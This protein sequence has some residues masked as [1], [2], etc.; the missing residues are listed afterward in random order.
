MGKVVAGYHATVFAYGQT[1][2]GK[3]YTMEGFNYQHYNGA[4]APSV[5]VAKPK[6]RFD[7][8]PEQHG[9]V[10]RAV[11]S[12][13]DRLAATTGA[14]AAWTALGLQLG[15]VCVCVVGQPGMECI[16]RVGEAG[17]EHRPRSSEGNTEEAGG[18]RERSEVDAR[19]RHTHT[20]VPS[21]PLVFLRKS[22]RVCPRA[23]RTQGVV[24]AD[25]A[26]GAVLSVVSGGVVGQQ[27]ASSAEIAETLWVA[28]GAFGC[29]PFV[30]DREHVFGLV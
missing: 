15:H 23:C 17:S 7:A 28:E 27:M 10:P 3:T 22:R 6:I 14:G 1:G 9:I 26:Q 5:A 24:L 29:V 2:S 8:K 25:E 30:V 13:F 18:R 20:K 16:H 11:A 4:A 19:E 21:A 12:L